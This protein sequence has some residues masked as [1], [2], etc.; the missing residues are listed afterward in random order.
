MIRGKTDKNNVFIVSI[1]A[2]VF[3]A[4]FGCTSAKTFEQSKAVE[5]AKNGN[6][7]RLKRAIS[8]GVSVDQSDGRDS[9]LCIAVEAGQSSVAEYL[10]DQGANVDFLGAHGY[11]PLTLAAMKDNLALFKLILPKSRKIDHKVTLG[12]FTTLYFAAKIKSEI[13]VQLLVDSGANVKITTDTGATAL[14][15]ACMN[16][17][18]TAIINCLMHAGADPD[19][20]DKFGHS[21]RFWAAKHNYALPKLSN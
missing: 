16:K 12:G 3:T 14:A 11:T 6:L 15:V 13:M 17:P 19:Q 1:L 7:D 8:R 9:L 20:K 5:S 4:C 2:L 21:P 10:I 18:N